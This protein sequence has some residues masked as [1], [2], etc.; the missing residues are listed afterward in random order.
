MHSARASAHSGC[1]QLGLWPHQGTTS[2]VEQKLRTNTCSLA[3]LVPLPQRF[4]RTLAAACYV[5]ACGLAVHRRGGAMSAAC[6][7]GGGHG[8]SHEPGPPHG[9]CT[10]LKTAGWLPGSSAPAGPVAAVTINSQAPPL[11]SGAWQ[12]KLV[13]LVGAVQRLL[14][15]D[16]LAALACS[17]FAVVLPWVGQ[18][19]VQVD[20]PHL[21]AG[22]AGQR[23]PDRAGRAVGAGR[24]RWWRSA[25]RRRRGRRPVRGRRP[26]LGAGS[27]SRTA[28]PG[29]PARARPVP[30]PGRGSRRACRPARQVLGAGVVFQ[31]ER[32][33]A[34]VL[35]QGARRV[36]PGSRARSSRLIAVCS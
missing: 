14:A 36:R 5:I 15:L 8:L 27:Q 11:R 18:R 9:G 1:P 19:Q 34:A 35:G 25:A 3:S 12:G 6:G 28:G 32:D 10:D 24:A 33:H 23:Q 16:G 17:L 26:A 20:Q 4:Y 2:A 13:V 30:R 22:V 7:T 21:A 31:Q 29:R